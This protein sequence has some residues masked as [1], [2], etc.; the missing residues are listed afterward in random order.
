MIFVA[1]GYVA[2]P[3]VL[4]FVEDKLPASMKPEVSEPAPVSQKPAGDPAAEAPAEKTVRV[5]QEEVAVEPVEV[6]QEMAQ[7]EEKASPRI[8]EEATEPLVVEEENVAVVEASQDKVQVTEE[9]IIGMMKKSVAAGEVS[10]FSAEDVLSWAMG[11]DVVVDGEVKKTGLVEIQTTT[12]FGEHPQKVK[13]VIDKGAVS[14]W[15]WAASGV[16]V[17]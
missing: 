5:E 11:A 3:L 7:Q 15:Q 1:I 17:P 2:H 6:V 12:I 9:S 4:P 8:I 10:S 16:K 13:A 14:Q